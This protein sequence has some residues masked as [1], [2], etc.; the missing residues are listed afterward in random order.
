MCL[1]SLFFITKHPEI[2]IEVNQYAYFMINYKFPFEII[3]MKYIKY[4]K[5]LFGWGIFFA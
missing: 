4:L 1:Y 3:A 5:E 2:F